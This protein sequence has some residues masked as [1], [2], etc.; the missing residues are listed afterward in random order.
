MVFSLKSK[1][2]RHARGHDKSRIR[3]KKCLS[4][5]AAYFNVADLNRHAKIHSGTADYKCDLCTLVFRQASDLD[6]HLLT[7]SGIQDD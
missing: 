6:R 1:L 3:D 7:H 2:S 4:C 5:D